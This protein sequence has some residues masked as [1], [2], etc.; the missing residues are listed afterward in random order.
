MHRVVEQEAQ[1]PTIADAVKIIKFHIP[2]PILAPG[3]LQK[4]QN[5]TIPQTSCEILI[6]TKKFKR[7]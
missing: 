4:A 1:N 5:P 3:V 6:L 7:I 2:N